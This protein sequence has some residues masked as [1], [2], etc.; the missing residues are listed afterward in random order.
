M[1][2]IAAPIFNVARVARAEAPPETFIEAHP[3]RAYDVALVR[4]RDGAHEQPRVTALVAL[5]GTVT[6][7]FLQFPGTNGEA[8]FVYDDGPAEDPAFGSSSTVLPSLPEYR[9]VNREI[10]CGS[11]LPFACWG[12]PRFI[13]SPFHLAFESELG[14]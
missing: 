4:N 9:T 10:G 5:D 13:C 7:Q 14:R 2:A 3:E 1:S 11:P 8:G 6:R 12:E